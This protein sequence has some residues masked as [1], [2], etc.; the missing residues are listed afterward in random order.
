[1]RLR[2]YQGKFVVMFLADNVDWLF[3]T[4]KY[5]FGIVVFVAMNSFGFIEKVIL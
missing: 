3:T 1:M 5:A 2:H 4:D